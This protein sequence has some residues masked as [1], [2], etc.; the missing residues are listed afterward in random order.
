MLVAHGAAAPGCELTGLRAAWAEHPDRARLWLLA[1]PAEA[2]GGQLQWL[3]TQDL[4]DAPVLWWT[5]ASTDLGTG[6]AADLESRPGRPAWTRCCGLIRPTGM[7]GSSS[8][9]W[10]GTSRQ[11]VSALCCATVST[12]SAPCVPA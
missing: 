11:A 5:E 7:D 12:N 4:R 1:C 2:L 3:I 6:G 9:P 8:V 10:H